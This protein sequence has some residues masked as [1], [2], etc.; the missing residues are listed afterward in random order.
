[1]ACLVDFTAEFTAFLPG[2]RTYSKFER[3]FFNIWRRGYELS[4]FFSGDIEDAD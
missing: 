2:G 1:M 3:A 4:I